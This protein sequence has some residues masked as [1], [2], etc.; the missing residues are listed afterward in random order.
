MSKA[1]VFA[2]LCKVIGKK[3]ICYTENSE[4]FESRVSQYRATLRHNKCD[5]SFTDLQRLWNIYGESSF[6]FKILFEGTKEEARQIKNQLLLETPKNLLFNKKRKVWDQ[7]DQVGCVY[8]IIYLR[9]GKMYIGST[10]NLNQRESDHFSALLHHR[11]SKCDDEMQKIFDTEGEKAFKV[12]CLFSGS[13]DEAR[14]KEFEF[15]RSTPR[16]NLFNRNRA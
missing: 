1:I 2:I 5:E 12:V 13:L 14:I 6:E 10:N 8:A 15:I 3:A 16:E 4:N 7:K 11:T 9:T